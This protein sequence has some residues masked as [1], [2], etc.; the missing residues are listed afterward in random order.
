V[1][2]AATAIEAHQCAPDPVAVV[3]GGNSAGQAATFLADHVAH[4][5]LV[6]REGELTANMSYYL[7]D[8]I[9]RN[10]VIEVLV[11][12]EVRE[13][14]G[15]R[16][17]EQLV[18]E[19]NRTGERRSLDARALFVFIGAE[20]HARWLGDE[21]ALDERGFVRTGPSAAG[22]GT[23]AHWRNLGRPPML[24]ETSRPGVFAAGDVRSGSVKRMAAAVGEGAM[25]VRMVHEYLLR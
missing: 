21:V 1:Y 2:Y 22:T 15:D 13:L 25:A 3:G 9:A 4:V 12:A 11:A 14:R 16:V 18:V 19:D 8:R 10:P 20:P 5:Y 7:A 24:L 23:S 6:I 17:L